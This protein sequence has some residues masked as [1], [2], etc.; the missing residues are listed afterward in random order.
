MHVQFAISSRSTFV[1]NEPELAELI[2]EETDA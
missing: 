1:I 2:H